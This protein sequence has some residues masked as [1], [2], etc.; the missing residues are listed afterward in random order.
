MK[1]KVRDIGSRY[2][3]PYLELAGAIQEQPQVRRDH[4]ETL[5]MYVPKQ[6]AKSPT[7]R[8]LSFNDLGLLGSSRRGEENSVRRTF[9]GCARGFNPQRKFRV[10]IA[11]P[12]QR[13]IRSVSPLFGYPN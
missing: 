8:I 11:F 10:Y 1:F 5:P 2:L 6:T 12:E 13:S 9:L 7:V 4:S 3:T